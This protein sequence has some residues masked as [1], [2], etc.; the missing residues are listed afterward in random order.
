[1]ESSLRYDHREHTCA[2]LTILIVLTVRSNE[3]PRGRC[4]HSLKS[5]KCVWLGLLFLSLETKKIDRFDHNI[6]LL[7]AAAR[8]LLWRFVGLLRS[9]VCPDYVIA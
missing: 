3:E 9:R 5:S 1:M 2:S 6:T 8:F 7:R 4:S